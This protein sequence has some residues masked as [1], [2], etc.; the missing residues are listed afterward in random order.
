MPSQSIPMTMLAVAL[1]VGCAGRPAADPRETFVAES[2]PSVAYQFCLSDTGSVG[3][4]WS[5][6]EVLVTTKYSAPG[7]AWKQTGNAGLR[8]VSSGGASQNLDSSYPFARSVQAKA[9]HLVVRDTIKNPTA[10]PLGIHLLHRVTGSRP[11][12][13]LAGGLPASKN[14]RNAF[15][16]SLF[17]DYGGPGLGLLAEDDVLR[18]HALLGTD[19]GLPL[20]A[21]DQLALAPG[22][23]VT[24]EWSLYPLDR[25]GYFAFVN[26]VRRNWG[27]NR[28]IH[29]PFAFTAGFGDAEFTA[30][31]AAGLAQWV[32]ER[33]LKYLAGGMPKNSDGTYAHGTAGSKSDYWMRNE[34]SWQAKVRAGDPEVRTYSYFHQQLS[35]EP[36]AESTYQDSRLTDEKG[37]LV[38]YPHK[39]RLPLF[40]PTPSNRYGKA[41][42]KFLGEMKAG[43]G[44]NGLYWDEMSGSYG[45][46]NYGGE[47]DGVTGQLDPR[48]KEVLALRSAVPL[49]LLPMSTAIIQWANANGLD[50]I[51][52]SMSR[53]TTLQDQPFLRFQETLG[54]FDKLANTHLQW[55]VG[56]ANNNREDT[57][58]DSVK[59]VVAMLDYGCVYYGFRYTRK[60]SPWNFTSVLYPITPVELREGVVLGQERILTNRSGTFGFPGGEAAEVVVVDRDGSR[61]PTPNVADAKVAGK[62]AYRLTLQPGQFA[63]LVRK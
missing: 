36:G 32:R 22:K 59:Q 15:N 47:W 1:L 62:R 3:I 51:A 43:I 52:N 27:S 12:T 7:G 21:D 17:A 60:A 44:M 29:G 56:L 49:Q 37:N 33:N 26:A 24:L 63:V 61:V 28:T 42:V 57:V 19:Q 34:R 9:D 5:D 4:R 50:I 55:P 45:T 16:P 48:T 31:D 39:E 35:T 8:W 30:K 10:R 46:Y 41:L 25:G 40:V 18:V 20:I 53:T 11:Q 54:N 23:T 2:A 38:V 14:V 58:E 13:V 6:Q